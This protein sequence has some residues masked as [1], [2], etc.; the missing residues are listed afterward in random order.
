MTESCKILAIDTS[1][2]LCTVALLLEGRVLIRQTQTAKQAAL[3]LLPMVDELLSES[4]LAL[5]ALDGIAIASGP[6]S[7]T[8]LR[9]GIGAVQGLSMAAQ[10]P[11]IS[12]SNLAVACYSA[13]KRSTCNAAIAC[14][15]A[16]DEEVYFGA[17]AANTELGVVL[18]GAEQVARITKLNFDQRLAATFKCW[19]GVGDAWSESVTL[20]KRLGLN[21]IESTLENELQIEDLCALADLRWRAGDVLD[22]QHVQPNYIKEQLDY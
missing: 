17:Y 16:R 19:T 18:V 7:F 13:I 5:S 21:V 8:G 9:I 1:S 2:A 3:S 15:H 6:G 4:A 10:I 22:P 14:F 12:L 11:V 20:E